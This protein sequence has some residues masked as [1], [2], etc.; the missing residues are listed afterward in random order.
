[1]HLLF[2]KLSTCTNL[3]RIFAPYQKFVSE[4]IF[5]VNWK[6]KPFFPGLSVLHFNL[7][8][9]KYLNVPGYLCSP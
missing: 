2:F 7:P 4:E 3:V 6:E 9:T 8:F 1:M 5:K